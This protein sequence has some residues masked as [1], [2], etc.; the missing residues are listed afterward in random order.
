MRSI[1]VLVFLLLLNGS[2]MLVN[3]W[4]IF[5]TY[6]TPDE[7]VFAGMNISSAA[8][9]LSSDSV[10]V[11][12]YFVLGATFLVQMI[13]GVIALVAK[14]LFLAPWMLSVFGVPP[15]LSTMIAAIIYIWIITD[16]I[17]LKNKTSLEVL[18]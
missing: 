16:L 18:R 7:Q 9:A 11:L 17:M 2:M 6:I 15:I 8:P 5:P 13:W 4:G 14:L 1:N 3:S 10:G 12:D